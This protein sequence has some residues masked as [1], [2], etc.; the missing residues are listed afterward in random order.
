MT[1][2]RHLNIGYVF[3]CSFI[4][5]VMITVFINV[6][7][8]LKHPERAVQLVD[9]FQLPPVYLSTSFLCRNICNEYPQQH[10]IEPL[11]GCQDDI[12]LLF[13]VV[14]SYDGRDRRDTI[15][16][17]WGSV[18]EHKNK[19]IRIIFVLAIPPFTS[20]SLAYTSESKNYGDLLV[21]NVTDS[22]ASLT[23]KTVLALQWALAFCA[24][25]KFIMKT[26]DDSF[27]VP[28]AVVDLLE[29]HD[30][31]K[32][33]LLGQCASGIRPFRDQR[34]KWFVPESDYAEHFFPLYLRGRGYIMSQLTASKL[35]LASKYVHFI[36][37]EDIFWT[38]LCRLKADLQ[39]VCSDG[40]AITDE[41]IM[42]DKCQ[43]TSH[44]L[45]NIHHVTKSEM[46]I[47]W[48]WITSE[49]SYCSY[50]GGVHHLGFMTC[51]LAICFISIL[52]YT[53]R[54]LKYFC[55]QT[56]N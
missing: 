15:R 5:A 25:A 44:D 24:S 7:I 19:T 14:S 48:S 18:K 41:G 38:G 11:N 10:I 20:L 16:Q 22:Y 4:I 13:L 34:N 45:I 37:M 46:L 29:L 31:Q 21:F 3:F 17:T 23:N 35:L 40:F 32:H 50:Q 9:Y 8:L 49:R 26:D 30:P 1:Y 47:Y 55:H 53:V 2:W 27:N 33:M 52:F 43:V 39:A 12:Y 42:A 36:T 6:L 51:I 28:W 56:W 54:R